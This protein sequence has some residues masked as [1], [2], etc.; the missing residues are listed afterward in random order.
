MDDRIREHLNRQFHIG[1]FTVSGVWLLYLLGMTVLGIVIR[2]AFLPYVSQDYTGYWESGSLRSTGMAAW[3]RC[4]MI[5]TI[6]RRHLC[7][8]WCLSRACPLIP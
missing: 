2:G 8:F 3:R 4:P 5:S 7:I 1:S 6:M